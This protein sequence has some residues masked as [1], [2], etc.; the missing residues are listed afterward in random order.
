MK[1]KNTMELRLSRKVI[2]RLG[3][4][5]RTV[6]VTEV[7][8]IDRIGTEQ[9]PSGK[10]VHIN[11]LYTRRSKDHPE[12]IPCFESL[13]LE[14]FEG[15]DP[16]GWADGYLDREE[17]AKAAR[18]QKRSRVKKDRWYPQMPPRLKGESRDQYA[19]R[20]LDEDTS[21]YDHERSRSCALGWHVECTDPYGFDCE[22]PCHEDEDGE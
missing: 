5:E 11:C 13:P 2:T 10:V 4:A 17:A 7:V 6:L 1:G 21:P 18:Q 22:C 19:T 12:G 16:D 14:C 9:I 8:D 20:L 3:I 15:H